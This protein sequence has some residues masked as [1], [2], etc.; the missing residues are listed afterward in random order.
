M[1]TIEA[2]NKELRQQL[3]ESQAEV[4]RLTT[5]L[6]SMQDI[7]EGRYKRLENGEGITLEQF[8]E[9]LKKDPPCSP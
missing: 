8:F 7:M 3:A 5:V 4:A 1:K 9:D 2:E 6:E